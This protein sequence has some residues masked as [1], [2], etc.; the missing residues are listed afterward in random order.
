MET[1]PKRR[2]TTWL[3]YL[4]GK[5]VT[6]VFFDS[7]MKANEVKRSLIEHDG[8]DFRITLRRG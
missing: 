2:F 4:D 1:Q 5:Q 7:D 8:F 3:V 6:A